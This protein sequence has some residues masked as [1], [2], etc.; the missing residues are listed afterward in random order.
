MKSILLIL[1]LSL[2]ALSNE[3]IK[4]LEVSYI[5]FINTKKI[6]EA[7]SILKKIIEI[8]P[9]DKKWLKEFI[10]LSFWVGD[11]ENWIKYLNKIQIDE[12]PKTQYNT[13]KIYAPDLYLKI[14]LANLKKNDKSYAY[15]TIET[16]LKIGEI[17]L[18]K[19]LFKK[20]LKNLKENEKKQIAEKIILSGLIKETL[21]ENLNHFDTD[22]KCKIL[23]EYSKEIF[24]TDKNKAFKI[25]SSNQKNCQNSQQFISTYIDVAKNIPNYEK[26]IELLEIS[27]KND[28]FRVQDA[29]DLISLNIKNE[30]F[31][32]DISIKAYKK[33][34]LKHFLYYYISTNPKDIEENIENLEDDIKLYFLLTNFEKLK[35]DEKNKLVEKIKQLIKTNS[36]PPHY[37]WIITEKLDFKSKEEISPFLNCHKHDDENLIRAV[38]YF[39]FSINQF[40]DSL[41]CFKKLEI[42]KNPDIY[43]LAELYSSNGYI[44]ETQF[45]KRK[46]YELHKKN[47]SELSPRQKIDAMLLFEPNR[48]FLK[49]LKNSIKKE[50][51]DTFLVEFYNMFFLS[52]K[53]KTYTNPSIIDKDLANTQ[54]NL[55]PDTYISYY[56]QIKDIPNTFAWSY[57]DINHNPRNPYVYWNLKTNIEKFK[58][59]K[60]IN[61]TFSTNKFIEKESFHINLPISKK[62]ELLANY[63]KINLTNTKVF[64]EREKE[65]KSISVKAKYSNDSIEI[66]YNKWLKDFLFTK[67]ISRKDFKRFSTEFEV[68]VNQKPLS[69]TLSNLLLLEDYIK[70]SYSIKHKSTSKTITQML[71]SNYKDLEKNYFSTSKIFYL[72]QQIKYKNFYISPH[73]RYA[74]YNSKKNQSVAFNDLFKTQQK[75]LPNEFFEFGITTTFLFKNMSLSIMQSY[76]NKNN[77]NYSLSINLTRNIKKAST[78]E[79]WISNFKNYENSN[80]INTDIQISYR[81]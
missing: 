23:S 71:L 44:T 57:Y 37:I 68:A 1:L 78:L 7:Y 3:D 39:K 20:Y 36:L 15:E 75:I 46:A 12:I 14:L 60:K 13:I 42:Q 67:Y 53:T 2:K 58:D 35:V 28:T 64:S 38:T 77:F 16:S 17:N 27:Y 69:T 52:E 70:L 21:I 30:E 8:K 41:N 6:N 43:T 51:R 26:Y 73:S 25:L 55:T 74:Y 33:F 81:F 22:T 63:S 34:N 62:F 24:F 65:E 31:I 11:Y 56:S 72:E 66:A 76:N 9:D 80:S 45:Y 47:N 19:D 40:N 54:K 29:E 5:S 32:R 10:N 48:N 18:L 50:E 59:F 49:E 4:L 61:Y 79:I